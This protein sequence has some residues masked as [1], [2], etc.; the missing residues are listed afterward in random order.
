METPNLNY[1]KDIA[2]G[3]VAFEENILNLLKKELPKD[4]ALFNENF[5]K[6][7][8]KEAAQ[9]VYKMKL[10]ISML[11]LKKGLEIASDFE[12]DLKLNDI[13]LSQ[14]FINVLKKIL[15]YLKD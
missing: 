10:K 12:K 6:K 13:K 2:A 3:D 11:G 7:K 8:Y 14:D 15:V 5:N 1:L 9:N 4:Y